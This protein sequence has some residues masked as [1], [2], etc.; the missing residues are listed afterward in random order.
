MTKPVKLLFDVSFPNIT[1]WV[2][3]CGTVEIGYDSNTD[4]FIRALDEGGM[5]WSGKSHYKSLDDALQ[6]LEE[7]LGQIL[8]DLVLG[9]PAF[10]QDKQS[11]GDPHRRLPQA[12]TPEELHPKTRCPGRFKSWM[13]SLKQSEAKRMSRSPG[14]PSSRSSARTP[15]LLG[16]SPCSLPS[17]AQG[18][19]REK[20]GKERYVQLARPGGQAK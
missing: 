11:E 10:C 17:K 8:V 12:K 19:L 15:T 14:S 4:S 3:D 20:Q 1:L 13:R 6:H 9:A 16:L 2:Q 5:V 7:G 18:R